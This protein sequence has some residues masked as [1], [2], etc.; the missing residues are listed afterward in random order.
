SEDGGAGGDFSSYD[1]TSQDRIVRG[2]MPT[3]ELINE[4]FARHLRVSLFNLLRRSADVRVGGLQVHKFAE[5][6]Q[7]LEMPTSLNTVRIQ[8]LRGVS[9][10]SLQAQLV[11]RLVDC[12]F[13]G[14]GVNAKIEGR[15]FTPTELR[16]VE[17]FLG[18]VFKDMEEAWKPLVAVQFE[19]V[20]A[21][22]NPAM[23]NI[24]NPSEA[25]IVSV[26]H[27]EV[28]GNGGDFHVAIPYSMIEPIKDVLDSGM[29]GES[30]EVDERWRGALR[31]DILRANVDLECTV[32]ER[33]MQ[34]R[35]VIDLEKGDIISVDIPDVL[36]LRANGVPVF[37][38]RMG[39]SR[40]SLA[41]EIIERTGI[42][43][44]DN[45]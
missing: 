43:Q 5:Y 44:I 18:Q 21:E 34:L 3:L 10:F 13:G 29:T 4:R 24:V 19:A 42:D 16:V 9:L 31:R 27:I 38:T 15:E 2:R 39:T 6:S 22:I 26:F 33:D 20:G 36:V 11:F 7:S 25:I 30:T 23:A 32:V 12:F 14:D 45:L 8:P 37:K 1:L 28:D 35:E 17:M 40:G 41:L